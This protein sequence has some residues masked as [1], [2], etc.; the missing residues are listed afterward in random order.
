MTTTWDNGLPPEP[1]PIPPL[2]WLRVVLRALGLIVLVFGGLT[3]LLL[4][5]LIE[6]PLFGM[7]RPWTPFITQ[8]VCRNALRIIGLTYVV[9]GKPMTGQKAVVAN[10]AS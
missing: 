6:R 2:G 5:R 9:S 3:L 8:F 4:V 7:K 1:V 10:H